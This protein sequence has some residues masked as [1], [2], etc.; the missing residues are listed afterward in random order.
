M[1]GTTLPATDTLEC[2]ADSASAPDSVTSSSSP[3]LKSAS[4]STSASEPTTSSDPTPF[5][6]P[7]LRSAYFQRLVARSL[8]PPDRLAAIRSAA[9][10]D[11]PPREPAPWECCDSACGLECVVNKW[12]EEEKSW[13]DLHPDWKQIKQRLKDEEEDRRIAAEEEAALNGCDGP[14]QGVEEQRAARG[15]PKIKIGVE[16]ETKDALPRVQDGVASLALT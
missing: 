7:L 2:T 1:I 9:Q 12:W 4:A 13:R 3:A 8:H 15:D 14:Q 10:R 6:D 16:G 11:E 5:P